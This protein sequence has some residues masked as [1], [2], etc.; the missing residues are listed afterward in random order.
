[1]SQAQ[2]KT[3]S[4]TVTANG[5]IDIDGALVVKGDIVQL[6]DKLAVFYSG[7]ITAVKAPSTKSEKTKD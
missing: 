4:Y 5:P 6:T 2:L 3:K 1:M 7:F